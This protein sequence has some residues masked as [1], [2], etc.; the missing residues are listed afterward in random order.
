MLA[1]PC[2]HACAC[3]PACWQSQGSSW[4]AQGDTGSFCPARHSKGMLEALS[5]TGSGAG[6][7]ESPGAGIGSARLSSAVVVMSSSQPQCQLWKTGFSREPGLG[8]QCCSPGFLLLC[9]LSFNFTY[10]CQEKSHFFA[11]H[12]ELGLLL[13]SHTCAFT[14]RMSTWL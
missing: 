11:G 6:L 5:G 9:F 10:L 13:E 1:C 7:L 4:S 14:H 12:L 2:V 8:T 3:V